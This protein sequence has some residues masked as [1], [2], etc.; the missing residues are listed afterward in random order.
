MCCRVPTLICP[1][2][3]TQV[4]EP[5]RDCRPLPLRNDV[6]PLSALPPHPLHLLDVRQRDDFGSG[7]CIADGARDAQPP[8]PH[9]QRAETR[10]PWL[11]RTLQV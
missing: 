4:G 10:C 7:I 8:W 2:P 3:P 1:E 11:C 5:F 9:T 6:H